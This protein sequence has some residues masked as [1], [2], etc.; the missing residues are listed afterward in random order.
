MIAVGKTTFQAF[1]FPKRKSLEF[2][3]KK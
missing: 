2:D 1:S 3:Q